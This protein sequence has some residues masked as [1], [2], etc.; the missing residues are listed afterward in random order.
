MKHHHWH[1]HKRTS[2]FAVGQLRHQSATAPSHATH[3]VIRC[4]SSSSHTHV[5]EWQTR[6]HNPP[7]WGLVSSVVNISG[8]MKSGVV[9]NGECLCLCQWRTFWTFNLFSLY[10]M[11]FMFHT[12]VDEAVNI[13]RVHYKSMKWDVSFSLGSISTLIR[14]GGHFCHLCVKHFFLFTTVQKL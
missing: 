3:A 9:T 4:R 7:D 1:E 13:L 6:W 5:A 12:V 10:L 14:W 8:A 11:N 2:A